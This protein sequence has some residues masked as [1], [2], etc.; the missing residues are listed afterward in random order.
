[1]RHS[2]FS[3]KNDIEEEFLGF[4]DPSTSEDKRKIEFQEENPDGTIFAMDRKLCPNRLF[5]LLGVH[6]AKNAS[7]RHKE[8]LLLSKRT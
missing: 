4:E 5:L 3:G 7:R 6:E 8:K 2:D 1:M